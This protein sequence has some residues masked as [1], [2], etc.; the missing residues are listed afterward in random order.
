MGGSLERVNNV[1]VAER[2]R[3]DYRASPS[4]LVTRV[5]Q[6]LT[7]I[8]SCRM[9]LCPCACMR[10]R[11]SVLVTEYIYRIYLCTISLHQWV[12]VYSVAVCVCMYVCVA[13][14]FVSMC[15]CA[16]FSSVCVRSDYD[17]VCASVRARPPPPPLPRE[18]T[19]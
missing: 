4:M 3:K 10:E 19:H 5:L 16:I 8:F 13:S 2:E 11:F 18:I 6:F 12:R 17:S 14:K 9:F 1:G 7:R 15:R